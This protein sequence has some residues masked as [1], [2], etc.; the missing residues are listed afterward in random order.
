[1]TQPS[2]DAERASILPLVSD[3]DRSTLPPDMASHREL[4]IAA[5]DESSYISIGLGKA[6]MFVGGSPRHWF[7]IAPS[8]T[9]AQ[10]LSVAEFGIT[11]KDMT[12]HGH[13]EA[14]FDHE[15][16]LDA[17]MQLNEGKPV[18][19]DIFELMGGM[20]VEKVRQKGDLFLACLEIRY[21]PVQ[22]TRV[23]RWTQLIYSNALLETQGILKE[24][25]SRGINL[26]SW[27]ENASTSESVNIVAE[28]M[29]LSALIAAR[30][31]T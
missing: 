7:F 28:N 22:E 14:R 8:G 17:D 19:R 1:M 9:H 4:V 2:I 5:G 12:G 25:I 21:K 18:V 29:A 20:L 6:R 24:A 13:D 27:A 15:L 10:G 23:A 30:K 11:N 3:F 16:A 31:Q 26:P